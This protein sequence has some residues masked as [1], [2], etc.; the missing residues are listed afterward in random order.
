MPLYRIT[1]PLGPEAIVYPDFPA[2]SPLRALY[3]LHRDALGSR[4]VR[5][6]K[7]RLVFALPEHRQ[8]CAGVWEVTPVAVNG[9]RCG[10][11]FLIPAVADADGARAA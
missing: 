5:L 6:E 2:I 3:H 11:K 4:S 8:M 10:V 1:G 7:G 9:P